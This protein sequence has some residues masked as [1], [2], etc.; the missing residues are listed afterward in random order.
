MQIL[1][2]K[3]NG[4]EKNRKIYIAGHTGMV[5][6]AMVRNLQSKGYDNLVFTPENINTS[7]ESAIAIVLRNQEFLTSKNSSKN[8][9]KVDFKSTILEFLSTTNPST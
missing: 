1:R 6:S 9:T 5:G 3:K 4:M 7:L 2:S 8:F